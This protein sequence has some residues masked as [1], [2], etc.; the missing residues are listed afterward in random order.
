MGFVSAAAPHA[1]AVCLLASCGRVGY[2]NL[3]D[4]AS[5]DVAVADAETD[6]TPTP[7]YAPLRSP[8][9]QTV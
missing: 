6:R 2:G 8:D 3:S 9:R 7:D 1:C 4:R 5:I